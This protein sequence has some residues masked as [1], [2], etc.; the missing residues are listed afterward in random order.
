MRRLLSSRQ[1]RTAK[2][3]SAH[4]QRRAVFVIGGITVG[5][6]AVA[7]ALAADWVQVAFGLFVAKWH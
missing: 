1:L 7:M 2:V 5:A 6:V 4:W 3:T